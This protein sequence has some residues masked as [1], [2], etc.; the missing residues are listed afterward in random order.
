MITIRDY[1]KSDSTA[2]WNI[3]FHTVRNINIRHY[4]LAQV[5]AW[6]PESF[7]MNAWANKLETLSPFVAEYH[8]QIVGY[9]DLQ[10]DGLIDHFFCHHEFQ[11]VG[12]GKALMNK[13]LDRG[14]SNQIK[15]Y[16]AQVS[17]TARPF[18]EHFGFN[19]IEEQQIKVRGEIFTNFVM[20]KLVV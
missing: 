15:R 20:E 12:V 19:V 10:S 1:Q 2:L 8:G 3:Y 18:F 4:S 17:I 11:G 9:A 16:Y 14:K 7:D 6:A 5:K 13:I